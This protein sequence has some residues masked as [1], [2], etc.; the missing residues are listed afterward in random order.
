M[1][2]NKYNKFFYEFNDK[3]DYFECHEILEEIWI[4]ETNQNTKQ[5]PAIILLLI[6]VGMHHW[7]KN[8]ISGAT[9]VFQRALTN[10]KYLEDVGEKLKIDTLKLKNIL[11]IKL[12]AV[13]NEET[14]SPF[15]IPKK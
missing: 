14:F 6:S 8:N 11:E 9:K 1:L 5:H 3:K 15:I 2:Q 13:I 12:T 10:Y 4:E 7:S